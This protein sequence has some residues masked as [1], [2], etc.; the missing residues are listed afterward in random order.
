LTGSLLFQRIRSVHEGHLF[1]SLGISLDQRDHR[2]CIVHSGP[3]IVFICRWETYQGLLLKLSVLLTYLLEPTERLMSSHDS[4][5]LILEE[6]FL[7]CPVHKHLFRLLRSCHNLRFSL[8][9]SMTRYPIIQ[10]PKE[11]DMIMMSDTIKIIKHK[12]LHYSSNIPRPSTRR[13]SNMIQMNINKTH[14]SII[15]LKPNCGPALIPQQRE[16]ASRKMRFLN[17][18]DRRD[19][20]FIGEDNEEH[21]N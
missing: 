17:S 15:T 8:L 14:C 11:K 13:I 3:D 16:M 21:A 4:N 19:K 1:F 2:P 20:R 9:Y 5:Q 7:H 12:I 10:I 18:C 6:Q